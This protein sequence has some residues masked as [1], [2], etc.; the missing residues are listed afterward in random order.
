M[1][2]D[3]SRYVV[4]VML[5]FIIILLVL[6][7]QKLWYVAKIMKLYE[8]KAENYYHLPVHNHTGQVTDGPS[9]IRI[10]SSSSRLHTRTNYNNNNQQRTQP[11]TLRNPSPRIS[12]QNTPPPLPSNPPCTNR[13]CT[14]QQQANGGRPTTGISGSHD[15]INSLYGQVELMVNPSKSKD[16]VVVYEK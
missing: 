11:L 15:S 8:D 9:N 1:T 3:W 6:M 5:A 2:M 4:G 7:L 16:P 13:D 10:T 12:C 14:T